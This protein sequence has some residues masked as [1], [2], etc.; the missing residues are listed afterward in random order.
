MIVSPPPP[1]PPAVVTTAIPAQHGSP[2][3]VEQ[4]DGAIPVGQLVTTNDRASKPVPLDVAQIPPTKRPVPAG[5]ITGTGDPPRIPVAAPPDLP[6]EILRAWRA[7]QSRGVSP[8]PELLVSEVGPDAISRLFGQTGLPP[9]VLVALDVLASG[10]SV[11]DG[12]S[13]MPGT[14]KSGGK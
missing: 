14:P 12:G 5:P 1:E 7:I 13:A 6:D 4:I 11:L 3:A 8:T 2:T 10:G 9:S